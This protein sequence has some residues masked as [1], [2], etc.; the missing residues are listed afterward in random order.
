MS[1]EEHQKNNK[2]GFLKL[3]TE[4][5]IA[6]PG[7]YTDAFG[8]THKLY[9]FVTSSTDYA[10]TQVV[11]A[12]QGGVTQSGLAG[13]FGNGGFVLKCSSVPAIENLGSLYYYIAAHPAPGD[14]PV[15]VNTSTAIPDAG[16]YT[17]AFGVTHK[18]RNYCVSAAIISTSINYD[19]EADGDTY[20]VLPDST[21]ALYTG[22]VFYIVR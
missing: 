10:T 12:D 21:T 17:D 5:S 1:P 4:T 7:S 8:V 15:L 11:L 14:I 2:R 18:L 9:I 3:N 16:S 6:D 19:V 13:N 20:Y 22:M